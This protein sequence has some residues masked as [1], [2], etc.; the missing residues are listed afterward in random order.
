MACFDGPIGQAVVYLS[1]LIFFLSAPTFDFLDFFDE[2]LILID[3]HVFSPL[4]KSIHKSSVPSLC[5]IEIKAFRF[6]HFAHSSDRLAS[7]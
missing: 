6:W 4:I 7:E 5:V 1:A 3:L 2:K